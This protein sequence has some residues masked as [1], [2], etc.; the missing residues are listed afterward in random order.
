M[1]EE[2]TCGSLATEPQTGALRVREGS[3]HPT[4]SAEERDRLAAHIAAVDG[5][6]PGEARRQIDE[7]LAIQITSA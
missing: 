5:I 7:F 2:V 6:T 4:L 3:G 1:D